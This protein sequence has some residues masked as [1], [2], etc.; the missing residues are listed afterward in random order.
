MFF[1]PGQNAIAEIHSAGAGSPD[2]FLFYTPADLYQMAETYGTEGR[3]AY[4]H[5]RWTFD[6][7]FP[8]IY[9]F[10]LI[11][12]ISWFEKQVLKEDSELRTGNI[13]P[14]F[15]TLF[16]LLENICTSLVFSS[17]PDYLSFVSMLA[18]FFTLMK[19]ICV[20]SSFVF[21]FVLVFWS[22]FGKKQ[23]A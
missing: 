20:G 13:L 3:A 9:T 16:D 22:F 12:S 4:I 7:A 8:I 17:Y 15:A 6:L 1:L 5:A 23:K 2:T 18:P 19:W 11:V 21:L 14:L 10:F